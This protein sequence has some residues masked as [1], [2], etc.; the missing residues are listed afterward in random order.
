MAEMITMKPLFPG[1]AQIDQLFH[2]F[3][4]LGTPNETVWPGISTLPDY[5]EHFPRK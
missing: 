2:I 5:N 1:G 3:R 4:R